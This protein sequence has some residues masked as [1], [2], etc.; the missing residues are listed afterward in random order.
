MPCGREPGDLPG[1]TFHVLIWVM[2]TWIYALPLFINRSRGVLC[3]ILY[4]YYISQL[5]NFKRSAVTE[6]LRCTGP[7]CTAA[8]VVNCTTPVGTTHRN[9]SIAKSELREENPGP[10]LSPQ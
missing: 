9:T 1:P 7:P 6:N 4:A 8:Q 5:K 3:I 2:I 10:G